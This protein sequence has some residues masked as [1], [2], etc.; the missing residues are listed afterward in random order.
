MPW[1]SARFCRKTVVFTSRSRPLPAASRIARRFANTCSVC[2]SMPAAAISLSPGFNASW[3]DT[4]TSPFAAIA[5]EYGAP[6][7]GAGAASVR[8]AVL[9]T[10]S[11]FGS[12]RLGERDAERLEDRLE[13]V[14]RIGSVQKPDMQRHA[15]PLGELLEEAACDVRAETADARLRQV[16]VRD[17]QR[18]FRRLE[19]DARECLRRCHRREAVPRGRRGGEGL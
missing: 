16:D 7:N 12:A 5:C 3:P 8:T 17:E 10:R 19:D 2:S 18:D 11:S 14:L 13:H 9:S 1:K 15:R 6:W 4:K